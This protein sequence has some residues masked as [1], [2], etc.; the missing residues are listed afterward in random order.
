M[1]IITSS[2]NKCGTC[3]FWGGERKT[4]PASG[5]VETPRSVSLGICGN[6][7]QPQYKGKET[8]AEMA[9]N[10]KFYQP[11]DKMK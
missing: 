9:F 11:W 2:S 10:C 1:A 3:Q 4:Y 8:K 7:K 5:R 6:P